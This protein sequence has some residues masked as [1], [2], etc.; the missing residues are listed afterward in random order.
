MKEKPYRI[1]GDLWIETPSLVKVT[2]GNKYVIV[3]CKKQS[4]SLK[5]IENGL[6]AFV[7]G[8]VNRPEGLYYH[9]FNYVKAHPNNHFKVTCILETDNVYHLLKAEQE[10]LDR[11][12]LN[13]NC[14]NNQ[15]EAYIP[16]YDFDEKSFG[17]INQNYVLNFRKWLK[18][19]K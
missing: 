12:F 6:N 4:S 1:I 15:T 19:R 10:E 16:E 8:G 5:N 13:P 9:L 2:Y 7:R 18:N 3:K 17:W 14:L 11:G